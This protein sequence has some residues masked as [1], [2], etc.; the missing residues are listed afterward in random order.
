M[1]FI[2]NQ[3]A[4]EDDK[5][6]AW[7]RAELLEAAIQE[8]RQL[9]RIGGR[10]RF[11]ELAGFIISDTGLGGVAGDETQLRIIRTCHNSLIIRIAVQATAHAGNNALLVNFFAVLKAAEIQRVQTVLIVND[12]CQIKCSRRGG[13]RLHQNN[14]G[15]EACVFVHHINEVIYECTHE[16]AFAKLQNAFRCIFQHISVISRLL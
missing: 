10:R 2:V 13:N 11:G 15:V 9:C 1:P 7:L 5:S 16:I 3:L 12:L 8:L 14:L 4:G 6:L